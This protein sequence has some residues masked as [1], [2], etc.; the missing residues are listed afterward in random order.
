MWAQLS[1]SLGSLLH[2][3]RTWMRSQNISSDFLTFFHHCTALLPT[4]S[5]AEKQT[6]SLR[7]I[8][9]TWS[10]C[11]DN[12]SSILGCNIFIEQSSSNIVQKNWQINLIC[13]KSQSGT[14]EFLTSRGN[15]EQC[16]CPK[17]TGSLG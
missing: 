11:A 1:A 3:P 8:C 14:S 13:Y 5:P 4:Q 12:K 9:T 15:N 10:L 2:K 17:V 6:F 7:N 16:K